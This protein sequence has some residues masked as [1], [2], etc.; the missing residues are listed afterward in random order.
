MLELLRTDTNPFSRPNYYYTLHPSSIRCCNNTGK[1]QITT[2]ICIL[3]CHFYFYLGSKLPPTREGSSCILA[4]SSQQSRA[5]RGK[6]RRQIRVQAS[7]NQRAA[8]DQPR[9][10]VFCKMAGFDFFFL[11]YMCGSS[12]FFM[13]TWYTLLSRKEC[14]MSA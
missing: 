14:S 11:M 1:S 4:G 10:N 8:P 5:A 9:R 12:R 2:R 3:H 6:I 13:C 7:T